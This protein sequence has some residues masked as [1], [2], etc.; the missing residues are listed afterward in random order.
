[1]IL[2]CSAVLIHFPCHLSF[3]FLVKAAILNV[4]IGTLFDPEIANKLKQSEETCVKCSQR[5]NDLVEKPAEFSNVE[6]VDMK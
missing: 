1:M 4:E 5:I 2:S 3:C 6:D